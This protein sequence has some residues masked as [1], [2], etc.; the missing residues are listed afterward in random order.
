[1]KRQSRAEGHDASASLW[2]EQKNDVAWGGR[3]FLSAHADANSEGSFDMKKFI[4]PVLMAAATIVPAAA[5]AEGTPITVEI[6]YEKALL[7]SDAGAAVVLESIDAQTRAACST[8]MPVTNQPYVDRSCAKD[9]TKAALKKI[10][11][12]QEVANRPT[13][14]VFAR[15]VTTL[16]ADAGQR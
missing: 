16:V 14:P 8:R 6:A 10:L 12:E 2:G 4:I 13:A 3:S 11:E 9:L 15:Q 5:T 1:M 7:A